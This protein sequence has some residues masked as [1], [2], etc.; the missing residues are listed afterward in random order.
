MSQLKAVIVGAG[1]MGGTIDDE[2]RGERGF[3]L[4]YS[5]AAGYAEFPQIDLAAIADLDQDKVKS[6]QDRYGI[7]RGYTDYREM[8]DQEKPDIVSVTTP[9][10]THAEVVVFAAEHGARG[11][12]AEKAFACSLA[13]ADAMVQAVESNNVKFNMG[14]LR[15]WSAGGNK[16][17]E[18]IDSGALGG[19]QTVISFSCGSLVLRR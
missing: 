16:A 15:R 8:I 4:P 3:V 6:L 10:H 18:I 14:T 12:Y 7:A 5:H 17:K 1:R 2:V 11:I 19:A 9:G 13:E